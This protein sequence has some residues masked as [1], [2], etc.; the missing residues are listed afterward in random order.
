MATLANCLNLNSSNPLPVTE[1][2]LGVATLTTPYSVVCAGTT[3]TGS[4]QTVASLGSAGQVLTSNGA[5][6]LPTWQ[7][8]GGGGFTTKTYAYLSS[9][10]SGTE[11]GDGTLYTIVF[12][13]TAF[14]I[15]SN[16]NTSTGAWTAAHNGYYFVTATIYLFGIT[17]AHTAGYFGIATPGGRQDMEI[18]PYE[19]A[20]NNG[21]VSYGISTIIY[22]TTG[23]AISVIC[24]V[25]NGGKVIGFGGN[26]IT[27][28][29]SWFTVHEI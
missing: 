18:G 24:Q 20:A 12:D 22:L 5:A 8:G 17:N 10:T 27:Y 21:Q 3:A 6:A 4:V 2:G 29:L 7:A 19:A 25:D 28:P 26:A 9:N 15:N 16:Y 11:T 13:A 14:D 23:Q 1:G